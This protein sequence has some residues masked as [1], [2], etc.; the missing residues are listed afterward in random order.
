[1]NNL[2][3]CNFCGSEPR[4]D[5]LMFSNQ[6]TNEKFVCGSCIKV[7]KQTLEE[8]PDA[9]IIEEHFEGIGDNHAQ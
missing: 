1:M 4:T 7:L 8:N 6:Q 2:H 3:Y 9:K 5:I